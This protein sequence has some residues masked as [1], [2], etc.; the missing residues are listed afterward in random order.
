MALPRALTQ[1]FFFLE[2]ATFTPTWMTSMNGV[3]GA[4][5]FHSDIWGDLRESCI[6]GPRQ[7]LLY[8]RSDGWPCLVADKNAPG[9]VVVAADW[10][11]GKVRG[12]CL[13]RLRR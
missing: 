4:L 11:E 12:S 1:M 5:R 7:G 10:L 13:E 6:P 2:P 8:G 9:G 3:A